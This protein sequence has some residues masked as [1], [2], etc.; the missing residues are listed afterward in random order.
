MIVTK[1]VFFNGHY[2]SN[3]SCKE[4]CNIT[5]IEVYIDALKKL[6]VRITEEKGGTHSHV[7][8]TTGENEPA[9]Q[10]NVL[11][12]PMEGSISSR[13]VGSTGSIM[14]PSLA[15]VPATLAT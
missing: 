5:V 4:K 1:D 13:R 14:A 10:I 7:H 9:K 11:P 3:E 2:I 6:R 15:D 8:N 12:H